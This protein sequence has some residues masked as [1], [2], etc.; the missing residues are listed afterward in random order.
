MARQASLPLPNPRA[1]RQSPPRP[2]PTADAS[3]MARRRSS[4]LHLL[5]GAAMSGWVRRLVDTPVE[6]MTRYL[7]LVGQPAERLEARIGADPTQVELRLIGQRPGLCPHHLLGVI[8]GMTL[9]EV[10]T[11]LARLRA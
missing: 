9:D 10:S 5:S 7:P 8:E 1:G 3:A 4:I 2:A 6:A 11:A